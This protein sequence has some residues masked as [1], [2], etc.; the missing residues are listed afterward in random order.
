MT[1]TVAYFMPMEGDEV[2]RLKLGNA[3]YET[4]RQLNPN[5]F[6]ALWKKS[7]STGERFDDLI[8]KQGKIISN[9]T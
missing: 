9:R 5:Q 2:D 7:M 6:T 3:R 8:D 1:T 4:I